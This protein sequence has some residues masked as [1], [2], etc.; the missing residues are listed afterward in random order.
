MLHVMIY[1]ISVLLFF[2]ACV[3]HV[4]WRSGTVKSIEYLYQADRLEGITFFPAQPRSLTPS[5]ERIEL[6]TSH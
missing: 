6:V 4:F 1:A 2:F 5:V 3:V